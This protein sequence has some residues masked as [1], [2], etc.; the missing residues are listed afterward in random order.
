MQLWLIFTLLAYIFSSISTSIDKYFMNNKKHDPLTTNTFKMFF[1]GIILLIIGLIFFKLHFTFNLFLWSFVLGAMYAF[2]SLMYF[3]ILKKRNAGTVIPFYDSFL[4][5]FVFLGSLIFLGEAVTFFNYIGISL[6]LVGV[7]LVLSENIFKFPKLDK[8]VFIIL[9]MVIVGAVYSLLVKKLLFNVEPINLAILMYFSTTFFLAI[10]FVFRKNKKPINIKSSKIFVSAFFGAIAL[11]LI[12][13][14]LKFGNASKVY[15][16]QGL[17]SVF[18]FLIATL[19]L[20]EKFV[21]H[22]LIGTIIVF[23]GIYLVTI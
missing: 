22:K 3:I 5:L 12:F 19:F 4:V 14:A 23:L 2:S 15:P 6:I 17:S 1:D 21:I 18:V 9:S 20:K 8:V 13:T 7:Y 16:L 11:F 10:F